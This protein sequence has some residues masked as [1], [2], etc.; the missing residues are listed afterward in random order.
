MTQDDEPWSP[1]RMGAAIEAARQRVELERRE[2][3]LPFG[4]ATSCAWPAS[5]VFHEHSCMGPAWAPTMTIAD[6][7]AHTLHLDYKTYPGSART[8]LPRVPEVTRGL[9]SLIRARRSA[10]TFAEGPIP[11]ENLAKVLE[12]GCGVTEHQ[13]VPRRA[14]PS[15]GALYPIEVYPLVLGVDGLQ[16]GIYH[17]AALA[18]ELEHVRP[19]PDAAPLKEFVPPDLFNAR[20]PVI[21]AIS[22]VFART[23]KKYLERGY[24]FALL[25]AGHIAQNFV[26]TATA[27]GLHSLCMGGY[28][29]DPFNDLLGFAP[30]DEAVVYAVLLGGARQSQTPEEP[31]E[32]S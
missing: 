14:T 1:E 21:L 8:P 12:I 11:L 18:H 26:L 20:P 9:E 5:R 13:D 32:Q 2:Q 15:G 19:L 23:Q 6:V 10:H 30:T 3:F 22:V 28:W 25:E 4:I 29:D 17:Y 27:L 24:R 16:N 31:N 7:E